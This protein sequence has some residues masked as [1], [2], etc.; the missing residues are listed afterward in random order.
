VH[1]GLLTPRYP[2]TPLVVH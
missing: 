2:R 1:I